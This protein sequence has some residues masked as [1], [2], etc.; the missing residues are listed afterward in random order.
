MHSCSEKMLSLTHATDHIIID[1][2]SVTVALLFK[3]LAYGIA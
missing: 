1:L 3:K 2:Y